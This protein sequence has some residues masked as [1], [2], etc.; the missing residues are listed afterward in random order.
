MARTISLQTGV[1]QNAITIT[2]TRTPTGFG[3]FVLGDCR[4]KNC[5]LRQRRH[6]SDELRKRV[7]FDVNTAADDSTVGNV[8]N[9]L[10]VIQSPNTTGVGMLFL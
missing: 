10:D 6:L 9:L 4:K 5:R 1:P 2:N 7:E 8:G 3:F